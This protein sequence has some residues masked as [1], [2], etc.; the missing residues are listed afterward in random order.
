MAHKGKRKTNVCRVIGPRIPNDQI[1]L[2]IVSEVV[3]S[4]G[5]QAK[6]F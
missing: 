4:K 1:Q 5:H 2:A 6:Q 3:V